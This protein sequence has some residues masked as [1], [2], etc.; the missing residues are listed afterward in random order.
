M[1]HLAPFHLR[2]SPS[3]TADIVV[4]VRAETLGA[5]ADA[6]MTPLLIVIVVPSTLTP[7]KSLA[8]AVGKRYGVNVREPVV[9]LY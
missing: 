1:T 5:A 6:V 9:L 4:S 7:P 8:V 2:I 3:F